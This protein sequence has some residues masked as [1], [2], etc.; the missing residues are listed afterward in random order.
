[1]EYNSVL[2]EKQFAKII[3]FIKYVLNNEYLFCY[4]GSVVSAAMS[5]RAKF[6]YREAKYN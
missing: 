5:P 6:E 1:M 3:I 2:S 4:G